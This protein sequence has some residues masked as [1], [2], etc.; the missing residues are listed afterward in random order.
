MKSVHIKFWAAF[1]II[2]P[3]LT[4]PATKWDLPMIV[5]L[6]TLFH[7]T[8]HTVGLKIPLEGSISKYMLFRHHLA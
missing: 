8:K 1:N 2:W 6:E 5:G 4:P 3:D 7:K